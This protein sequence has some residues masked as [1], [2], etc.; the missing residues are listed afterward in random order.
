MSGITVIDMNIIPCQC[1][2]C[3]VQWEEARSAPMFGV[4]RYEDLIV[5]DN[6]QGEWGGM[7]VCKQCFDA[8]RALHEIN[9]NMWFSFQD[10]RQQRGE[11]Q[12]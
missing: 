12:A 4:A 3:D 9:P 7:Q 10:V 6:Y 11:P 8:E 5:P 2:I 1:G